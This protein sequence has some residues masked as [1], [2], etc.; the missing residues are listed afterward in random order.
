MGDKL[1][2]KTLLLFVESFVPVMLIAAG[3]V[4]ILIYANFKA[5]LDADQVE[6]ITIQGSSSPMGMETPDGEVEKI[7]I[8]ISNDRQKDPLY[9]KAAEAVS[10]E[11]WDIA[12]NIY[13]KIIQK[14]PTSQAF[15]NIGVLFYN[16]KKYEASLLQF[17]KAVAQSPVFINA[18][19][20][21][22]LVYTKLKR[23]EKAVEDYKKAIERVPYHFQ[24]HMNLGVVLI[25]L[26]DYEQAVSVLK[27]ASSLAGGGRKAKAL[28]NLGLA[29]RSVG[30][31]KYSAAKKAFLSAIRIRPNYIDARFALAA[32]EPST[33][34]GIDEALVQYNKVLDLVPQYPPAYFRIAQLKSTGKDYQA[35]QQNYKKAIQY[36]PNYV[37]AR[38]NLGLSYLLSKRWADAR[39]QFEKILAV[40]ME[41]KSS[42]ARIHFQLG[43]AAYG[44]KNYDL[45]LE[46][47]EKALVLKQGKYEKARLNKGLTY[48]AKKDYTNAIL[49]Y[50]KVLDINEENP[51]AW[52][53]L[54]L[55]Y[56][57]DKKYDLAEE[58]FNTA[59][60]Y[61]HDYAQAW[62]NLGVL[63]RKQSKNDES[64]TAYKKALEIRPTYRKAKLNLAVR[65]ARKRNY[66]DAIKLY[67]EVLSKDNR[68][69][70]AWI[71]LGIAYF[72]LKEYENAENALD[73][74][75]DL[76]PGNIKAKRHLARIQIVYKNYSEAIDLLQQAVDSNEKNIQLRLEL[77]Q[78][79]KLSGNFQKSVVV[80]KKALLLAP[81]NL[82]IKAAL[83]KIN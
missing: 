28:Y 13:K 23:Y 35:A 55:V 57:R 75:I 3:L 5:T 14:N 4:F 78:A 47:Y 19:V 41:H 69:V 22:G 65:Y 26:K 81:E 21:R 11:K 15:N 46:E 50:K 58:S 53:N 30:E 24:A 2:N 10:Q 29:Y 8:E 76:Q 25:K 17:D 82:K 67:R 43:R 6:I 72:N 68:Y 49:S 45:A 52:Y 18:Y 38:Y 40:Q 83:E 77:G 9:E 42:S 73:K 27:K 70:T 63:Y 56:M 62:F 66:I 33:P 79:Y 54:G 51:Q 39:N 48:K 20:S 37:K 59:I 32:L 34:S 80:L 12:E 61:K 60:D 31:D 64:I 7:S 71:N 74:A 16:Q 1:K 36:N 44:E